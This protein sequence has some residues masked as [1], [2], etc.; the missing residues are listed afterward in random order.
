M[1]L[2]LMHTLAMVVVIGVTLWYMYGDDQRNEWW[3]KRKR[4]RAR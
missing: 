3:R 1:L 2:E 4:K